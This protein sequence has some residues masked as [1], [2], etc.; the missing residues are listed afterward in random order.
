MAT[1]AASRNVFQQNRNGPRRCSA[2]APE[3]TAV[4]KASVLVYWRFA[5]QHATSSTY[6]IRTIIAWGS[7]VLIALLLV[8]ANGLPA[9]RRPDR[10][11]QRWAT[12]DSTTPR[13]PAPRPRRARRTSA[14]G[15]AR[16]PKDLAVRQCPPEFLHASIGHL[17]APQV[18]RLEFGQPL[19]VRQPS[20][21]RRQHRQQESIHGVLRDVSTQPTERPSRQPLG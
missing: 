5:R 17:R 9:R 19:Q 4:Q 1:Q 20:V 12:V 7:D 10:S 2:L 11:D 21:G 14:G 8:A 13:P 3:G 16:L 18:Q 6:P 15:S